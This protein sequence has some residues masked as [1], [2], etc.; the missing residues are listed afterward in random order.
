MSDF[1]LSYRYAK[2]ILDLAESRQELEVVYDDMELFL[3]FLDQSKELSGLLRKPI[4]KPS[5]KLKILEALFAD[6][7]SKISM[8]FFR[9]ITR[10]GRDYFL[11]GIAKEYIRQYKKHKGIVD[12]HLTTAIKLDQELTNSVA[13]MVKR[14]IQGD[15]K[16]ISKQDEEVIG[17]FALRIGDRQIDETIKTK[18]SRL[19][20]GLS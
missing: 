14:S 11:E 4:V 7:I 12:A 18:L 17:G 9:L 20:R 8:E 15:I 16:L 3:A 6:K 5:Q 13:E 2:S 19:K 1:K 10:K